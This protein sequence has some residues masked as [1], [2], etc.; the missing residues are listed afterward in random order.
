MVATQDSRRFSLFS[1][2]MLMTLILGVC[3]G[4]LLLAY[5]HYGD[6]SSDDAHGSARPTALGSKVEIPPQFVASN[7]LVSH[8]FSVENPLDED[9]TFT[10]VSTSCQ[11]TDFALDDYTV[12]AGGRTRLK[13][14]VRGSA[15]NIEQKSLS[16]ML[17]DSMKRKWP[18]RVS[19]TFYP[20]FR[21]E[22]AL[23]VLYAGE[24]KPGSPWE[25]S[26]MA[27]V[28]QS[29][30]DRPHELTVESAGDVRVDVEKTGTNVLSSGAVERCYRVTVYGGEARS[31]G[32]G[33]AR[34][35]FHA[36]NG[37]LEDGKTL[38]VR[39]RITSPFEVE[40]P[41][42]RF[43]YT[44]DSPL[45]ERT[46]IVRRQDGLPFRILRASSDL[47]AVTV[48]I[49]PDDRASTEITITACLDQR[50]LTRSFYRQLEIETDD[51]AHPGLSLWVSGIQS[52][53]PAPNV[54]TSRKG[55]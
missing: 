16:I 10:D 34:L 9:V 29:D 4:L 33:L 12:P 14:D 18:Y 32:A 22:K 38:D 23:S 46:V 52:G 39:W 21:F 50:K 15:A 8:V 1:R 51:P 35:A 11:C 27:Y 48:R 13:I 24:V 42:V 54:V 25:E 36:D 55:D 26:F 47:E 45:V 31:T 49:D 5:G 44:P 28:Y 19:T 17:T 7:K 53:H 3:C 37:M 41:A 43:G 6:R 30:E 2:A 40:P 20:V